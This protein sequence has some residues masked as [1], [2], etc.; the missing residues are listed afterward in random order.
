MDGGAFYTFFPNDEY[1]VSKVKG[2]GGDNQF[3]GLT[4]PE[5]LNIQKNGITMVFP[6]NEDI[7]SGSFSNQT[8]RFSPIGI[9][10]EAGEGYF[11]EEIVD[12]QSNIAGT[13]SF[14][15][16]SAFNYTMNF[17]KY[18]YRSSEKVSGG[19]FIPAGVVSREVR[20]NPKINPKE[21]DSVLE[22]LYNDAFQEINN[23]GK[24][25]S[26]AFLLDQ[27]INGVKNNTPAK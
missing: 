16:N 15:K 21:Q 26:Q 11:Q 17:E 7:S 14:T 18:N 3:A 4:G 19:D 27:A 10:I 2:G 24:V 25:N 5:R 20:I 9:Q 12:A 1:F 8:E 23:L 13:I 6:Q 22:K